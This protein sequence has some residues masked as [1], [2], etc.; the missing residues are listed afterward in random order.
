MSRYEDIPDFLRALPAV[1]VPIPGVTG[2]LL[3]GAAQQAVFIEFAET[4]DVPE[5]SHQEQWE[6]VLTGTVELHIG[7]E[8]IVHTAGDNFFVPADVPHAAR[9]HAG[10]KAMILFN[11]PDRYLPKDAE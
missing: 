11:A 9:V 5:H 6:F 2:T 3:Q 4:V 1:D 8:T 7:G 10:Y